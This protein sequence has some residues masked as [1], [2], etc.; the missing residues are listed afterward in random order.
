MTEYK[1]CKC[2]EPFLVWWTW[3]GVKHRPEFLSPAEEG[4]FVVTHCPGCGDQLRYE[5]LVELGE[6]EE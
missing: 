4:D 5:A 2:G 3:N 6:L 1:Y